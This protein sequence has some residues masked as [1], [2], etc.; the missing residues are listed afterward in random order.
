M[1]PGQLSGPGSAH[2]PAGRALLLAQGFVPARAR[3]AATH[4]AWGEPGPGVAESLV[5]VAGTVWKGKQI[6]ELEDLLVGH[7]ARAGG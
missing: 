1:H 6:P 7:L 5:S 3:F 2:E 4:A